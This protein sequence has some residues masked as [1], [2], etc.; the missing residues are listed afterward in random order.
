MAELILAS[1]SPRR[2]DLLAQLGVEFRV[3]ASH[4]PEVPHSGEGAEA[5]AR[6]VARAKAEEVARLHPQAWV[7]G[8]DTIVVLG[9]RIL[10]KPSDA[11]EARAMLRSL[12]GRPHEVLTAIVLVT[13]AGRVANEQAV[14]T[15]VEF[16]A[17]GE[18]EIDAY[19][20][21]GEPLDKA[22]AYAIQGGAAEFVDHIEGSY[23]NVVGFPLDEVSALLRTHGIIP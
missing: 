20:E 17:L 1:A 21:S 13:P 4:V 23:T 12:S 3:V 2:R 7:L 8:A 19:V 6:R 14:R 5:F 9:S 10:G 16:R 11:S 15:R 18:P 22:G